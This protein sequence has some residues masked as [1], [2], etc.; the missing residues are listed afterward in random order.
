MEGLETAWEV[1]ARGVVERENIHGR[2]WWERCCRR[3]G[4]KKPG[5]AEGHRDVQ[6]V[7]GIRALCL[8]HTRVRW[9][10]VRAE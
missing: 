10:R 9:A 2:C 4:R 8:V 5:G 6:W 1:R 7:G 3:R